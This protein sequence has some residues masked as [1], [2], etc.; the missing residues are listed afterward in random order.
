MNLA[1][2]LSAAGDRPAARQLS[3]RAYDGARVTFGE[4]HPDTLIA[5][6][7]FA[8]DRAAIGP[9]DDAGPS[10]DMVLSRLRRAL[11]MAHPLVGRIAGGGRASA[12]VEPP[13]A[14]AADQ[15]CQEFSEDVRPAA[16][17]F[18][19]CPIPDTL[20]SAPMSFPRTSRGR[21]PTTIDAA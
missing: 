21:V 2:A 9:G 20:S 17:R 4:N 14:G 8:A 12:E 18:L 3:A 16:T 6:A 10:L 7:N 11:G 19:R 1:T 5:A 13:S 15:R